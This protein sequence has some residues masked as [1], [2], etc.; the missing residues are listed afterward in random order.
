MESTNTGTGERCRETYVIVSY[1]T[2]GYE[3]VG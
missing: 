3:T 1:E 2:V